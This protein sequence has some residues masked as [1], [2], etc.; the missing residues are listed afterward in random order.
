MDDQEDASHSMLTDS[1]THRCGEGPQS[2]SSGSDSVFVSLSGSLVHKR[3]LA[4]PSTEDTAWTKKV[5]KESGR[6][7]RKPSSA[8][9]SS[10][11][12]PPCSAKHVGLPSSVSFLLRRSPLFPHDGFVHHLF[13]CVWS[14]GPGQALW[15]AAV[16]LLS[17]TYC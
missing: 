14:S 2:I 15:V 16:D 7:A 5:A 17:S 9:V 4:D 6:K 3:S 12:N 13:K 8:K 1:V 11:A 10:Q